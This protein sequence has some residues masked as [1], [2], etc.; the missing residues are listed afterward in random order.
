[1]KARLHPKI[2]PFSIL[3]FLVFLPLMLTAQ[4]NK[5]FE[6]EV[7]NAILGDKGALTRV[8][9]IVNGM[10]IANHG[11]HFQPAAEAANN[12]LVPALNNLI[13]NNV[14]SFPLSS[15]SVG[16]SFDFS[17]GQPVSI[18]EGLGPILAER[19]RTLGKNKINFG[20]NYSHLGLSRF[21]GKR[22]EDIMFTFPHQDVREE[23]LGE[24][25]TESDVMDI[26]LDLNVDANIFAFYATIGLAKNFDVSIALPVLNISLG[27]DARAVIRSFTHA[28]E[29]AA[30]HHFGELGEEVNNPTLEHTESYEGSAFGIGDLALRLKYAFLQG[31]GVGLA[32][33]LDARLPTGKTEDFLGTGKANIRL[34]GIVSKNFG[35]F[36]PHLNLG[37]D[38]RRAD[39]DSDELEFAAGFDHKITRGFTF[40]IDILGEIDLKQEEALSFEYSEEPITITDRVETPTGEPGTLIRTIEQTNIPSRLDDNVFNAAIGMRYA[41]AENIILLG[42]I[43]LPLN[44]GGLR[45]NIAYTLGFAV[46]L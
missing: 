32:A 42:N 31:K 26:F 36:T 25:T 15:T 20:V 12:V 19:G 41:P 9:V 5:V 6:A 35:D 17:T 46:S 1:M 21:R 37:Y 11:D 33:L 43:L 3:S 4:L 22:T 7:F 2:L 23:G 24:T 10:E 30:D 45:S 40:A 16:V 14:S 38:Y 39:F 18:T 27:G 34:M 8:P 13:A 44:D 28:H 29:G